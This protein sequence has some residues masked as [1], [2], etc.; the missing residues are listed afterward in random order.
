MS[1]TYVV[2]GR[3]QGVGF[4]AA[5]ERAATE[6]GVRGH[7]RNL[8]DGAVEVVAFGAPEALA[9][10]RAWLERGPRFARVDRIGVLESAPGDEGSEP[11]TFRVRRD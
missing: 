7:V 5:T 1:V 11:L 6:R 4:R 2:R 10:L 3:V 8:P 9:S